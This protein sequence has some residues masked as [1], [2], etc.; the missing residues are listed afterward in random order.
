[1]LRA[2]RGRNYALFF[3]GQG[4]SLIG[5]WMQSVSLGLLVWKLT[6]REMAL[7]LVGFSSQIFAFLLTPFAGVFSDRWNRHRV[8]LATQSLA[9][10]QATVLAVLTFTGLVHVGHIIA[11]AAFLGLVN[12]FDMP[13]RQAFVVQMVERKED[14]PNAI[15][16]N[17]SVFNGARLVGPLIAAMLIPLVDAHSSFPYAGEGACFAVNAVSFLAVI[18]ALLAMR[19]PQWQPSLDHPHVL[20]SLREGFRYSFGFAPI[21][22]LLFMLGL[23]SLVSMPYSVLLPA[24]AAKVLHAGQVEIPLVSLGKYH[25]MLKFEN[26]V[27]ILTSAAGMGALLG[28]LFLASR[29]SILGLG[30]LIPVATGILGIA[31]I[32]FALSKYVLLSIPLLL[33]IG[34]GFMTQMASSNTILQTIVDDDKR[35]RVM[36]F[37]TMSFLGTAPFGALL[38]GALASHI[39]AP[40]TILLSG[41]LAVCGAILF[42]SRLRSLRELIRP[43]YTKMGIIPETPKC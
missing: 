5:T 37:Y 34:F 24:I 11:L 13:T 21:R 4:L 23:V 40:T 30:R 38:A 27:G 26:T 36:S 14:L 7:G 39:G 22:S 6:N 12:A 42:A 19:L 41:V 33:V 9:T 3:V 32:G 20:H 18:L 28:A 15:A 25:I 2:L 31:M 29:K 16:L 43:I 10:V 35:G 17:S 8:L 1:M